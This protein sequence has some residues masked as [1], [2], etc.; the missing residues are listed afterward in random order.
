[1]HFFDIRN[2]HSGLSVVTSLCWIGSNDTGGCYKSIHD[3]LKMVRV[4]ESQVQYVIDV[5]ARYGQVSVL[6]WSTTTTTK[7]NGAAKPFAKST[8]HA[9]AGHFG[10]F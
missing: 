4:C 2:D 5:V 9:Y 8:A 1:M 10:C 7:S 3:G 6:Q